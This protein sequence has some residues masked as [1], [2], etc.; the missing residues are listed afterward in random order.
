MVVKHNIKT[1]GSVDPWN[2]EDK[3]TEFVMEPEYLIPKVTPWNE[4]D[5][6]MEW[7]FLVPTPKVTPWTY[8]DGNTYT[9]D[10]T[11]IARGDTIAP[12]P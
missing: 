4:T 2:Y 1:P 3:Y 9:W 12:K 11:Q 5:R 8:K 6:Y 7:N 10:S